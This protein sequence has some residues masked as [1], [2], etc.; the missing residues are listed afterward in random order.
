MTGWR[1]GYAIGPAE[2]IR[3]MTQI[4][5]GQ[6]YGL[7]TLAQ[8]AAVYALA[9]HDAKLLERQK[10]FAERM[11]YVAGR[12]NKMKGVSCASAEGAFYLFPSVKGTGLKSEEFVWSLLEKARVAMI[13]GS[14][15]GESGEGYV[16]IACTRSMEVL[17]QAMDKTEDFLKRL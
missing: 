4:A 2:L 16:R 9:N 5:T 8:K 10:V 3:V 1:I 6:T 17:K 15:F 14:A 7:N 13:P 11:D 12:L